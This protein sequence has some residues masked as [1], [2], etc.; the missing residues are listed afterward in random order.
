[1]GL[2]PE[3]LRTALEKFYGEHRLETPGITVDDWVTVLK[4]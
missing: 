2:S 1:V 3:E 4:A